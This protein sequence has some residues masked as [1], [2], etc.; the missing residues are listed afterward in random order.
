VVQPWAPLH[1]GMCRWFGCETSRRKVCPRL[2][3]PDP[4]SH[5]RGCHFVPAPPWKADVARP[6]LKD[7]EPDLESDVQTM[8]PGRLCTR[9][10]MKGARGPE[11]R[12]RRTS[13]AA[14]PPWSAR[15]SRSDGGFRR[16]GERISAM[17]G[18]TRRPGSRPRRQVIGSENSD[19]SATASEFRAMHP[20]A[21]LRAG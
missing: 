13:S 7:V 14:S 16:V 6:Q 9:I 20:V 4:R 8:V 5:R 1:D 2:R 10:M 12:I 19:A 17:R 21:G 15:C 11:D 3:E 18:V